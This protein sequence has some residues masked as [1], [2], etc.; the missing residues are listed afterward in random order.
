[1]VRH[2]EQTGKCP[3][4]GKKLDSLLISRP[5]D[6]VEVFK[7]PKCETFITNDEEIA[8]GIMCAEGMK[9]SSLFSVIE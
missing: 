1:M 2:I 6:D 3:N 5:S 9:K 8:K 7:C 4:C